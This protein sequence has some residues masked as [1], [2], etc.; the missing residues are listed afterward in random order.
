M[1]KDGFIL[2]CSHYPTIKKLSKE[3]KALLLDAIFQYHIESKEPEFDSFPAEIAFSFLK[4][5]FDR[6]LE[7]YENIVARNRSNIG[8]RW[9]KPDTKNTTGKNGISNDTKNTDKDKD[10]DNIK[11]KEILRFTPP[12]LN[13]ISIYI[14]ENKFNVSPQSFIDFYTAN[15]WKIGKNGMKDWKATIRTW[16][17]RNNTEKSVY[18]HPATDILDKDIVEQV[19]RF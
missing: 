9:N 19:K 10:K 17:N 6:D 14:S 2:Y 13:E 5:Q 1:M 11:D 15:G 18:R 7:K 8:K 16:H 3:D 4:Q 12:S